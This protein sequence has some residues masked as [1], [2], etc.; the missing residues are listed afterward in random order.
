MVK[1]TTVES[2]AQEHLFEVTLQEVSHLD[3]TCHFGA[4]PPDWKGPRGSVN[5]LSPESPPRGD[6]VH[7]D[8]VLTERRRRWPVEVGLLWSPAQW[9]GAR[10]PGTSQ[11][12]TIPIC[13]VATMPANSATSSGFPDSLALAVQAW[14]AGRA[15]TC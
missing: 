14:A 1:I 10:P 5:F 4:F 3:L 7:R 11:A 9:V 2:R 13:T 15:R 8:P 6:L 12:S